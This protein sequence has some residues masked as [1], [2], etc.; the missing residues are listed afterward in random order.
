[1]NNINLSVTNIHFA[2]SAKEFSIDNASINEK[3]GFK[4]S[5]LR[6]KARIDSNGISMR[7]FALISN[8]SHLAAS[9]IKINENKLFRIDTIRSNN[10][11]LKQIYCK[12]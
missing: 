3:S 12:W 11:L 8:H 1:M 2:D 5:H 7:D 9:Q 6:L 10:T 4:I